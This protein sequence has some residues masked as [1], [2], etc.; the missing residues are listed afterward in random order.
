[1]KTVEYL[2][3]NQPSLW[4]EV[5]KHLTMRQIATA[6]FP[7]SRHFINTNTRD[8]SLFLLRFRYYS[9]IF[10]DITVSEPNT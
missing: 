3:D 4:T 2:M 7:I 5:I 8:T 10:T 1:M 6:G 9:N